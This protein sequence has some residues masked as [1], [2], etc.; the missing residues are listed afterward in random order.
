M[1]LETDPLN[2]G[3]KMKTRKTLLAVTLGAGLLSAATAHAALTLT[4][5]GQGVYDTGLN[6][7]WLRDAN[8]AASNTFG[9]AASA[10]VAG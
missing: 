7:T 6:I 4:L 9:V 8:L 10:Q 2:H 3:G 5:G 1:Q